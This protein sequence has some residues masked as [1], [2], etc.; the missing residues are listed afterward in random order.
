MSEISNDNYPFNEADGYEYEDKV[1][2]LSYDELFSFF[3]QMG[4][5]PEASGKD[6]RLRTLCHGGK[7]H[8]A[9]C[10]TTSLKVTCFSGCGDTVML[11]NWVKRAMGL[12]TSFEAKD[13]IEAWI[14]KKKIDFTDRKLREAVDFKGEDASPY[15]DQSFK[16]EFIEPLPALP[17]ATI[18]RLYADFDTTPETLSRLVWHTKD[19]IS[20]E[21]L[22]RFQIAFNP[23]NK[24]I[25]LPHHNSN[26]EIVGLYERNFGMLRKEAREEFPDADEKF[27][28][29][30][31]KS[32]YMPLLRPEWDKHIEKT[33]YSF[34]NKYNLYGLHL[35]KN[36]IYQNEK[37]VVFEGAKSVMLAHDYGYPFAVATHTFGI[38]LS[39]ISMLLDCGAEEIILAFDRQYQDMNGKE[40][41]LYEKKTRELAEKVKHHVTVSRIVDKTGLLG[42]KDAPIDK[43]KEIFEKLYKEREI[44]AKKEPYVFNSD[45]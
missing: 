28:S 23:A 35:A 11:H 39:H 12:E 43:G 22:Q 44:L 17:Q 26:G 14:D 3:Q 41:D 27:Y 24:T 29:Q 20:V 25:I 8:G 13:L 34:H 15:G 42:Y 1:S 6:I 4:A 36:E 33:R 45:F 10:D 16:R 2:R 37:V 19:G 31:P 38:S 18:E 21:Q 5:E 32:K 7:S 9:I 40:W 30:F